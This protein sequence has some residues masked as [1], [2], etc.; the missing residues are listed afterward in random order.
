MTRTLRA[1]AVAL[2]VAG[3]VLSVGCTGGPGLQARFQD[4]N[5]NNGWPERNGYLARQAVLHPFETQANN[6]VSKNDVIL[7]A[8][9]ETGSDKLNPVGKDKL[10]QLARRMPAVNPL[11]FLQTANDVAYDEKAPERTVTARLDL[12]AKRAASVK[13]YLSSRPA[14]GGVPFA[15]QAIDIQDPTTNSAGPAAAVRGLTQQYKSG[16]T[17]GISGGNPIGAGGGQASATVGVSPTAGG[18]GGYSGSGPGNPGGG[19]GVG[20]GGLR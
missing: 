17:G 19:M 10:D 3:G 9:F 2:V 5:N 6:A 4:V 18:T 15:V 14:V 12:D 20:P 13:A 16:I 1:A 7:N 8:F 11:I